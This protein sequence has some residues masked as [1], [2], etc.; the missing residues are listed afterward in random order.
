M[1]VQNWTTDT[2]PDSQATSGSKTV[3]VAF[4][5]T[6]ARYEACIACKGK[7]KIYVRIHQ[8]LAKK[9]FVTVAERVNL[10]IVKLSNPLFE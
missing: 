4:L 1:Q 2:S 6:P 10:L 9:S 8:R 7:P 5:K 3:K